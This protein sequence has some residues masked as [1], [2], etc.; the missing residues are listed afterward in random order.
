MKMQSNLNLNCSIYVSS[1]HSTNRCD[2]CK[3]VNDVYSYVVQ[4]NNGKFNQRKKACWKCLNM[5]AGF[6]GLEIFT[7]VNFVDRR[8]YK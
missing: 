8:V 5:V 4:H 7:G 2:V 1:S 6:F 3:E